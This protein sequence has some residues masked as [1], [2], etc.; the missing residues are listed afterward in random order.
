MKY[1]KIVEVLDRIFYLIGKQRI[2]YRGT[3][4]IAEN[5]DAM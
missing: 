3:Q 4:E 2:S 5:S 1:P